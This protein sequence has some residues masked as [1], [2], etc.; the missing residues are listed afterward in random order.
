M[1]VPLAGWRLVRAYSDR[2]YTFEGGILRLAAADEAPV[3]ISFEEGL[4]PLPEEGR[5]L[6]FRAGAFLLEKV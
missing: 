1:E 5:E 2:A 4:Y 6:L 3:G